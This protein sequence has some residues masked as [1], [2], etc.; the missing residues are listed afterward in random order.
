MDSSFS[1]A[2]VTGQLSSPKLA[3]RLF[4]KRDPRSYMQ[5]ARFIWREQPIMDTTTS[6][7]LGMHPAP[8]RSGFRHCLLFA[9]RCSQD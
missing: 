4:R 2:I 3:A 7:W 9:C 6:C 5:I 8:P 1:H